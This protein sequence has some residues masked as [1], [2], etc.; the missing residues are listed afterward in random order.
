MTEKVENN[1]KIKICKTCGCSNET[2]KFNSKECIKCISKR[3][4]AKLKE[5]SYYKIY[6]IENKDAILLHDRKY[7]QEVKKPRLMKLKE[8]QPHYTIV[9]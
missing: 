2:N 4:N 5:K 9:M 7:Y 1:I 8:I 3:N 6:Y